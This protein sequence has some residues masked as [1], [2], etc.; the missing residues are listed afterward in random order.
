[1]QNGAADLMLGLWFGLG[2]SRF[3]SRS[4][5]DVAKQFG[6]SGFASPHCDLRDVKGA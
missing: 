3:C 4:V 2:A 6:D 1:L 5:P